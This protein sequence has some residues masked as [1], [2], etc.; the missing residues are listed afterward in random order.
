MKI[1]VL[2]M[3][4]YVGGAIARHL[5]AKGY[6]VMG[7][8]RTPGDRDVTTLKL[9]SFLQAD[10][11]DFDCVVNCVGLAHER[12][13][14]ER[15]S[16]I[17]KPLTEQI[18]DT[19]RR[20]QIP[21]F[22]HISSTAAHFKST[23]YGRCEA[24]LEDLV[25][26]TLP[27]HVWSVLRPA[28][29]YG[30]HAPGDP[31]QVSA[32]AQRHLPLPFGAVTTA[33]SV[34]FIDNVT[35]AAAHI[36]GHFETYAGRRISISDGAALPFCDYVRLYRD[37]QRS[38]SAVV[39][40]PLGALAVAAEIGDF[41]DRHLF[42]FRINKSFLQTLREDTSHAPEDLAAH[43]PVPYSTEAAMNEIAHQLATAE[44]V[45]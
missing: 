38:N 29:I 22:L 36:I 13:S 8:V 3:S 31:A 17:E 42:R 39:P 18:L 40:V 10:D 7:A 2:G 32:L 41:V 24:E 26:Q 19:V 30:V 16:T 45:A 37:A 25:A 28:M 4:S 27:D 34:V 43:I 9:G 14:A 44:P 21:R 15:F 6:H 20:N 5:Q 11:L 35:T 23:E 12:F 1:A 33:K